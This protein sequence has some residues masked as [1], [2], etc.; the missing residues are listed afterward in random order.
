M[1]ATQISLYPGNIPAQTQLAVVSMAA[2]GS[3]LKRIADATTLPISTVQAIGRHFGAPNLGTL[4]NAAEALRAHLERTTGQPAAP[5]TAS[6]TNAVVGIHTALHDLRVAAEQ[7]GATKL[8]RRVDQ[9]TAR[10]DQLHVDLDAVRAA[11]LAKVSADAAAKAKVEKAR[12]QQSEQLDQ[13]RAA[14]AE[15][16]A[17]LREEESK[18]AKLEATLNRLTPDERGRCRRWAAEQKLDCNEIGPI[19]KSVRAA[20]HEAGRP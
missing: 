1:T 9:I 12:R 2:R 20:W 18:A 3:G 19:P 16:A 6:E 7:L 5:G 14:A 11:R 17:K 13:A 10:I 15:L 8:V 4:T